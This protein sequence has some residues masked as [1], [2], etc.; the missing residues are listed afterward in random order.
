M[1]TTTTL[2]L[3]AGL[4]ASGLLLTSGARS[5]TPAASKPALTYAE[6]ARLAALPRT[7]LQTFTTQ[8]SRPVTPEEASRLV[9]KVTGPAK[10]ALRLD[11]EQGKSGANLVF[12]GQDP[13]AVLSLNPRRGDFLF[14]KGLAAYSAEKDTPGLPSKEEALKVAQ[15][16]LDSLALAPPAAE[17]LVAHVGGLNMAVHRED[18]TTGDYR[19]LVTVRFG[20]KLGG[21]RVVG[22]SRAI[23]QIG[24]GGE[25]AG[26]VWDWLPAKGRPVRA[27]ELRSDEQI[28]AEIERRIRAE[29][30]SPVRIVVQSQEL[31]LYD[32]GTSIE[33]AIRVKAERTYRVKMVNG[34]EQGQMREYTVP[35]DA[36]V[37]VLAKPR[38]VY[39]QAKAAE[40][41]RTLKRDQPGELRGDPKDDEPRPKG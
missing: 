18:G 12:R 34:K 21:L 36:I 41:M 13:S 11:K 20:R 26:L 33:P 16:H 15:R 38:A 35:Y 30:G 22:D 37:P 8:R 1:K 17:S 25:L 32:D 6:S 2:C 27:A 14:N 3:A 31:V 23:V 19:K 29:S 28:R 39:P 24:E 10:V 9:E 40:V 7:S 5:Q 4:L